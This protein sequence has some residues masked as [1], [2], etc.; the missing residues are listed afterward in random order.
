MQGRNVEVSWSSSIKKFD[1]DVIKKVYENDIKRLVHT[2]IQKLDQLGYLEQY[3]WTHFPTPSSGK[4]DVGHILS[5]LA[6][7]NEKFNESPSVALQLLFSSDEA[8]NNSKFDLLFTKTIELVHSELSM[9]QKYVHISFFINILHRMEYPQVRENILKYFSLSIWEN[10]SAYR[11]KE[12]L[13]ATPQLMKLWDQIQ[14]QKVSEDVPVEENKSAKGRKRKTPPTSSTAKNISTIVNTSPEV[15]WIFQLLTQFLHQI[16]SNNVASVN[17]M[18]I[19]YLQRFLEFLIDLLSQLSTR[20]FL[21]TLIDDMHVVLRC[22]RSEY[23][24]SSNHVQFQRLVDLLEV[25][26]LLEVNDQTG[27]AMSPTEVVSTHSTRVQQLQSLAFTDFQPKLRDLVFASLGQVS[28]HD[29]LQKQFLMLKTSELSRLTIQLG[30][31]TEAVLK[32]LETSIRNRLNTEPSMDTEIDDVV[33][34]ETVAF[35]QQLL[36]SKLVRRST[37]LEEVNKLSLY[38]NETLLWDE[39]L[40]PRNQSYT[41]GHP[42]AIPKLNIQFLSMHDYLLRNFTLFRLESAF[43]IR[44]DIVDAI[45]RMGPRQALKLEASTSSVTFAGWARMALPLS[46]LSIDEV[47]N[48]VYHVYTY[49][50]VYI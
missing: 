24:T 34:Q 15:T 5:I 16:E 6:L 46:S 26:T 29:F 31:I 4:D 32:Q 9:E 47:R 30:Y 33:E 45:K 10:L 40:V 48:F 17:T 22:K 39:Q 27:K 28:R 12:E 14:S 21:N 43:E 1:V 2:K 42:C 8:N 37:Q 38:P 7:F 49:I 20:R 3:L 13:A 25:N 44:E 11:L 36:F 19:L 35:L 41:G 18:E 23:Y 50:Y